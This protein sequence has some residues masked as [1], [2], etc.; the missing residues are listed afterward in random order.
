MDACD[1]SINIRDFY[2]VVVVRGGSENRLIVKSQLV[3]S[4]CA[5]TPPSK[6]LRLLII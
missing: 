5:E 1:L 3:G 6:I 4:T 2:R